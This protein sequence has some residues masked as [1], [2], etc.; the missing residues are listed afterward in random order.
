[1]HILEVTLSEFLKNAG[2]QNYVPVA[3]L[4]EDPN[5][6]HLVL[7]SDQSG[8]D[9]A[10]LPVGGGADFKDLASA[11]KLVFEGLHARMSV[12]TRA[13]ELAL[14]RQ[15]LEQLDQALRARER[16]VSEC[17]H[18]LAGVTQSLVTREAQLEQREAQFK[19]KQRRLLALVDDPNVGKTLGT[20]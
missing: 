9:V 18:R 16:Y 13:G 2:A 7:F 3:Q 20:L 10:V 5:L 4:W 11:S 6:T 19:D 14:H 15:D 12:R 17:E 1:M 8:A